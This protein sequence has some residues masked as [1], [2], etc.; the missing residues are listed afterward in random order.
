MAYYTIAHYLQG[1]I[2]G[3]LPGLL[4]IHASDLKDSAWDYIFLKRPYDS[5][6]NIPEAKLKKMRD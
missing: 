2:E 1:D 6:L 4:G 5:T 3:K